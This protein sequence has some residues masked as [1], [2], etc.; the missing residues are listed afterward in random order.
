MAIKSY[1][2]TENIKSPYVQVTGLPHKPQAIKFKQFS[3]GQI[4][5]GEM[6]HANNQPAFLLVD[7]VCVVPVSYVKEVVT[8]EVT[9]EAA[10]PSKETQPV[11]ADTKFSLRNPIQ[12]ADA[13]IIGALVG[14]AAVYIAE[15]QK[16]IETPDKKNKL[17]GAGI[18]ALAGLYLRY[19]FKP[20]TLKPKN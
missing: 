12:Y 14:I 6:K 15:K 20:Q 5:K 3:K 18:G 8:K 7:G 19:R 1:I 17:Y 13:V 2:I 16:W 4:V 9:S 11:K 10:G